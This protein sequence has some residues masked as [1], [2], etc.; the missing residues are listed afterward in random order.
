MFK[1]YE[2]T[3]KKLSV[4][5][6]GSFKVEGNL[7]EYYVRTGAELVQIK[8][9]MMKSGSKIKKF[10]FIYDGNFADKVKLDYGSFKGKIKGMTAY[11]IKHYP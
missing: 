2:N 10:T 9:P 8:L 6:I 7:D 1:R 5:N 3:N 11:D 4:L